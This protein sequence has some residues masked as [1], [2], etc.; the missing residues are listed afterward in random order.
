MASFRSTKPMR[1]AFT[2]ATLNTAHSV[3]SVTM[4][5]WPKRDCSPAV[6]TLEE[7]SPADSTPGE[8]AGHGEKILV[9]FTEDLIDESN[10]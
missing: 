7:L 4:E 5:R 8:L 2:K 1:H 9:E 3:Q 6:L 10:L